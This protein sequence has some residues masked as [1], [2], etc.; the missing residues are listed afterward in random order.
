MIRATEL[1]ASEQS[2]REGKRIFGWVEAAFNLAYLCTAFF[3]AARA[4]SRGGQAVQA[5]VGI[6]ALVLAAGDAFHLVPRV[7]AVIRGGENGLTKALG[8]GKL[9]TSLSMTGFY[10]LLWHAGILLFAPAAASVWTAMVYIL[11]AL[12]IALCLCTKNKWFDD[13]PPAAWAVYRNIPFLL[14]GAAVAVFFG[15]HAHAVLSIRWM[16]FAILLSFAF[17]IPVVL[18]ANKYRK[19]GMLMLPK[20]CT[21]L[22]MLFM[23]MQAAA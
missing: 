2:K 8:F 9:V 20:T 22:W 7:I 23:L 16:G 6:M 12:R 11:A 18:W 21:Y 17:Y 5:L 1:S 10:V 3:L 19:L 4:L 13:S 15:M 14:L